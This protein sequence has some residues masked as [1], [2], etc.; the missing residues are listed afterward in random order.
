MVIKMAFLVLKKCKFP[1]ILQNDSKTR[2][3]WNIFWSSSHGKMLSKNWIMSVLLFKQKLKTEAF[4]SFVISCTRKKIP[5]YFQQI[6]QQM[7]IICLEIEVIIKIAIKN[8]R[9]LSFSIRQKWAQIRSESTKFQR[10]PGKEQ[11][12]KID[13]LLKQNCL[14]LNIFEAS[15]WA[16]SHFLKFFSKITTNRRLFPEVFP[17]K[18]F[19]TMQRKSITRRPASTGLFFAS[20]QIF[21]SSYA[22]SWKQNKTKQLF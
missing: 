18:L 4:K 13:K 10:F 19:K 7:K 21:W 16:C 20:L 6:G 3:S 8:K 5:H 17:N 22:N 9:N 1:N 14:G 11:W 15:S 2:T 12:I